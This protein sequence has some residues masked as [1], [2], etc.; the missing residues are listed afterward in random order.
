[1]KRAHTK[2][3]EAKGQ[4]IWKCLFGAFNSPKN[5]QKQFDLRYHSSKVKS[6]RSFF[7]RIEDTKKIHLSKLTDL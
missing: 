2:N 1:M 5:E 3:H 6:F 7:G 4:L